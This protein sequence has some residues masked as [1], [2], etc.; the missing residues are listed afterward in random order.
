VAQPRAGATWAVALAAPGLGQDLR[1]RGGR[2]PMPRGSHDGP[3]LRDD[4]GRRR[5]RPARVDASPDRESARKLQ[6]VIDRF[7]SGRAGR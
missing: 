5:G 4:P 6:R 3:R 1:L 2:R 7:R